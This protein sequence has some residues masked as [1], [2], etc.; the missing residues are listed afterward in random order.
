MITNF[1]EHERK[2]SRRPVRAYTLDLHLKKLVDWAF[3]YNGIASLQFIACGD[4]THGG[5]GTHA[6]RDV[7]IYRSKNGTGRGHMVLERPYPA[8]KGPEFERIVSAYR[9]LL[10]ACPTESLLPSFH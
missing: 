6:D 2:Y 8:A 4:R 1:V 9:D 3:R 7:I 10:E 5:E